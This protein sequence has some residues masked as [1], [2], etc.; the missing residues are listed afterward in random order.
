MNVHKFWKD[1]EKKAP[2]ECDYKEIVCLCC[3]CFCGAV[4]CLIRKIKGV[5]GYVKNWGHSIFF[6]LLRKLTNIEGA[7][8]NMGPS[9]IG[10]FEM[11]FL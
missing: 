2:K 10:T 7:K 1:Q 6:F 5:V 11:N 9:M 8:K 3:V 4:W